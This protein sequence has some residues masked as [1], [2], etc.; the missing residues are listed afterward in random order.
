MSH[1]GAQFVVTPHAFCVH[2]PHPKAPSWEATKASGYWDKLVALYAQVGGS[3][4]GQ[5]YVQVEGWEDSRTR[6]WAG[7]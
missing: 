3:V 6:R 1:L 7:G 4:G 2:S 5:L